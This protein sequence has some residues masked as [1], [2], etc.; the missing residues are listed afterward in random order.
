MDM[1]LDNSLSDNYKLGRNYQKNHF[2]RIGQLMSIN[3]NNLH[4]CRKIHLL[5]AKLFFFFKK[6]FIQ[7]L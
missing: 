5:S 6:N 7:Y 3:T 2:E 1:E 4:T